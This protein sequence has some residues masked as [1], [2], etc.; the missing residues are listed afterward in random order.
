MK[1]LN[2]IMNKQPIRPEQLG[3]I[4]VPVG[5]AA[6]P[7]MTVFLFGAGVM[8]G[9]RY[10]RLR[11]HRRQRELRNIRYIRSVLRSLGYEETRDNIEMLKAA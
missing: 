8:D 1:Y 6:L 7:I 11:Y 5:I 4:G 2:Y 10:H 9:M 3:V